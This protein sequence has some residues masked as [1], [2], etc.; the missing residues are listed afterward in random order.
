MALVRHDLWKKFAQNAFV[1]RY[2]F[3]ISDRLLRLTIQCI[4]KASG[5]IVVRFLDV[6]QVIAPSFFL[7]HPSPDILGQVCWSQRSFERGQ[8]RKAVRCPVL[9]VE[10]SRLLDGKPALPPKLL[11]R[12]FEHCFLQFIANAAAHPQTAEVASD[13]T[14]CGA[15]VL[16]LSEQSHRGG[17]SRAVPA[18]DVAVDFR[19]VSVVSGPRSELELEVRAEMIRFQHRVQCGKP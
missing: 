6:I 12:D 16:A 9:L 7:E 5:G 4:F 1:C 8:P 11:L 19:L 10:K 17:Q 3:A 13:Q 15:A 14:L 18:S 2:S